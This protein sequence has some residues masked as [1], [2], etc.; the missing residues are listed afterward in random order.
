MASNAGRRLLERMQF[1]MAANLMAVMAALLVV[2]S[3][4]DGISPKRVGEDLVSLAILG[5]TTWFIVG[6]VA[7]PVRRM[8]IMGRQIG[9]ADLRQLG[10]EM[11]RTAKGDFTGKLTFTAE[12]Y[13]YSSPDEVGALARA[14]NGMVDE[15]CECGQSFD[16]MCTDLRALINQVVASTKTVRSAS[17]ALNS[18]A[19]EASQ[20]VGNI[21][22]ATEEVAQRSA[23]ERSQLEES[24]NAVRQL[25]GSVNAVT[26]GMTEMTVSI[27]QVANNAEAVAQASSLANQA[28]RNGGLRV[29]QTIG[30]M[31][32]FKASFARS[33]QQIQD[34]GKHS[35]E[36][37]SVVATINDIA[38]QTNL[39]ALNA[40]IEAARA[41]EH[42][43]SFGVVAAEVR[44]L[45]ERSSR[46]TKE[47]ESLILRVQSGISEAVA[48]MEQGSKDVD[49]GAL[50]ATDAEAA[51]DEIIEAVRATNNQIQD[52]SEAAEEMTAQS[53]LTTETIQQ[54]DRQA[55]LVA[56]AMSNISTISAAN[57]ATSESVVGLAR[58]MLVRIDGMAQAVKSL[59]SLAEGLDRET[60]QFVVE[61]AA[62]GLAFGEAPGEEA[63]SGG[64]NGHQGNGH[65]NGK[66]GTRGPETD[67]YLAPVVPRDDLS[68][69][70]E[71]LKSSR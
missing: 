40:A 6:R 34:L 15:L 14:L 30:R 22:A 60:S 45:A 54:A 67:G 20:A 27:R 63:L 49:E 19:A 21:A 12:P 56:G 13:R 11:R 28:A 29:S 58:D 42:G 9:E 50:E 7:D 66:S 1:R 69:L 53:E 5:V 47:I 59:T 71:R 18:S 37:G 26:S 24:A 43:K 36:I 46:A 23:Q 48:V 39:L 65:R 10:R 55:A 70:L 62:A 44:K 17:Q 31:N 52:I 2:Y 3:L 33:M 25:T 51:L 32:T 4:I 41:G 68:A 35:N 8:S 38:E 64:G 61:P 57:A 16:L